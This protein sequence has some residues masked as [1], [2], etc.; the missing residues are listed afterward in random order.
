M[1]S[2]QALLT[3]VIWSSLGKRIGRLAYS[4]GVPASFFFLKMCLF[5]AV[6]GLGCCTRASLVA[7]RGYCLVAMCGLLV[8]VVS[9]VATGSGGFS[10]YGSR[11]WG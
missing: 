6:L 11:A 7:S 5:L 8:V 3:P 1:N 10:S 9:L 4:F 2:S